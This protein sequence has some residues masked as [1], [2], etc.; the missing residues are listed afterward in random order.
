M[1]NDL[2]K[3]EKWTETWQLFFNIDKCLCLYF[4]HNNPCHEYYLSSDKG[5]IP[6][7]KCFNEK[8]LGVVFDT[9]LKFDLHVNSIVN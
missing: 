4:G 9:D 3:L 8:D 2:I 7:K 1:Q 6:V 5:P